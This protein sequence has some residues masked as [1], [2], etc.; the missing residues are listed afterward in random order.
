MFPVIHSVGVTTDFSELSRT[1]FPV[2]A[3]LARDFGARLF[4]LHVVKGIEI[5]T[6]WQVAETSPALVEERRARAQQRLESLAA[7]EESFRTHR[8]LARAIPGDSAEA[9][10]NFTAE[11]GIDVL[12]VASHGTG[13]GDMFP[14]GSFAAKVLQLAVA[15]VLLLHIPRSPRERVG[16]LRPKR[17][18]ACH[19]FSA[20]SREGLEAARVWVE[21]FDATT[22]LLHVVDRDAHLEEHLLTPGESADE[23]L[24]RAE[25]EAWE[26]L[27]RLVR[28]DWAGLKVEPAV[29][30]GGPAVEILKEAAE[31]AVDLIVLA[32]RGPSLIERLQLGSVAERV[33]HGARCPVLVVRRNAAGQGLLA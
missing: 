16:A 25:G 21:K 15:P 17:I 4:L 1:A 11:Q 22:R 20:R 10:T 29:R 13:A 31:F 32:S 24:G 12:V 5:S 3:G 18:L 8:V 27:R 9:L 14:L 7:A 30:V 23:R 28:Q 33:V 6:P 19:D 26:Q 2:A